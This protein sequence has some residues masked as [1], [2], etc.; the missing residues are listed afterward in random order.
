MRL[1]V[2][3]RLLIQ[4]LLDILQQCRNGLFEILELNNGL[5]A[6]V[7]ANQYALTSAD[8]ARTNLQTKRNAF[9]S[10]S[11]NFQPG[12]LSLRSI[13]ARMPAALTCSY[14]SVAFSL[15]PSL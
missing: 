13:L 7:A 3:E 14:S 12:V 8:I 5:F 10:Y 1:A 15:T 4:R 6:G 11:A 9:I 2:C